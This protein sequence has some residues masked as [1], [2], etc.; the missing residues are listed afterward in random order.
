VLYCLECLHFRGALESM[1]VQLSE[2]YSSGEYPAFRTVISIMS[3]LAT[4]EASIR[5]HRGG[6]PRRC[7]RCKS[8]AVLLEVGVRG[9][10]GLKCWGCWKERC[11][12]KFCGYFPPCPL[13]R[14]VNSAGSCSVDEYGCWTVPGIGTYASAPRALCVCSLSQ[15]PCLTK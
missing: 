4:L 11:S 14:M 5:L 7:T 13:E 1:T 12:C 10:C 8:W 2:H 6:V 9:V 3:Q 15:L